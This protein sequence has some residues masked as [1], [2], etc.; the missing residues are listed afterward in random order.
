MLTS[1]EITNF[2]TFSHLRIERLG[3][4]NLIVGKNNVGKTTLLEALR[5]YGMASPVALREC[6]TDH[7]EWFSGSVAGEPWLDLRCL[8]HGR[9]GDDLEI[10]LGPPDSPHKCLRVSLV[11][12]ECVETSGGWYHYEQVDRQT[13]VQ[14]GEIVKGAVLRRNQQ[15]VLVTPERSRRVQTRGSYVGPAFVPAGRGRETRTT[16]GPSDRSRPTDRRE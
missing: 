4:V 2:R 3:R 14:E 9:A 15:E 10:A 7:E 5:F 12:V 8:F 13:S 1:F 11:D 6:L 16:D